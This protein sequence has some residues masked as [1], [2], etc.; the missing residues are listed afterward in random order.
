MRNTSVFCLWRVALYF[1]A[2]LNS[3]DFYKRIFLHVIPV[4]IIVP[5][6]HREHKAAGIKEIIMVYI[7]QFLKSSFGSVLISLGV[8][9]GIDT[10]RDHTMYHST[11]IQMGIQ[12]WYNFILL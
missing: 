9:L 1:K 11:A 6:L 3:I 10:L 5:C 12:I 2:M 4:C 8:Y 7:E